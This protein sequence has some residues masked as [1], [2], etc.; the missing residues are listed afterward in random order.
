LLYHP[1]SGSARLRH[2]VSRFS[3]GF[4]YLPAEITVKKGEPVVL[5]MHSGDVAHGIEFKELGRLERRLR[6]TKLA[7]WHH[8]Y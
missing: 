3:Q 7:N 5:V 8:T 4:A 2:V 1:N 6:R